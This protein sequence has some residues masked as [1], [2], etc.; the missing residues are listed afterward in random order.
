MICQMWICTTDSLQT[1]FR[2]DVRIGRETAGPSTA[3]PRIS[4]GGWW[5][6][7]ALCGFLYGK[8]HTGP[9]REQRGRKSG[10]APVGMT[11]LWQGNAP[12]AVRRMAVDG[13]AKLSSR[14]E[15]KRSGGTCGFSSGSHANST[16]C[17]HAVMRHAEP[18]FISKVGL[19][20]VTKSRRPQPQPLL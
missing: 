4:C 17:S 9:C 8:P 1:L 5:R 16:P 12:K 6:W 19:C 18:M 15:R 11:T 13:P 10:Y 20:V 7:R 14:P 2:V 3:L